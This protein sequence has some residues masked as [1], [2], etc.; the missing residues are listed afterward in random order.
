MVGFGISGFQ[1]NTER[2]KSLTRQTNDFQIMWFYEIGG[3]HHVIICSERFSFVR[4]V[5]I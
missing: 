2:G 4:L 1:T 3:L 5:V